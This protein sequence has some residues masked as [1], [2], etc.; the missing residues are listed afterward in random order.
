M[1]SFPH[2]H[3]NKAVYL[4]IAAI[5]VFVVLTLAYRYISAIRPPSQA[6]SM[7]LT[8][9]SDAQKMQ[10]LEQ[11]G[12]ASSTTSSTENRQVLTK[13]TKLGTLSTLSDDQK[14]LMLESLSR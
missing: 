5:L 9:L 4:T 10:L 6:P 13:L 3:E 14:V 11:L 2:F 1:F 7:E 8:P 12:D